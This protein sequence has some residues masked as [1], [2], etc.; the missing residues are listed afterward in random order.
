MIYIN[1]RFLSQAITGVQ[2]YAKE[3]S[4]ELLKKDNSYKLIAPKG[5]LLVPP[6]NSS[7][8]ITVGPQN[9]HIWEQIFLPVF[10]KRNNNPLIINF[11]G[12][13]PIF[14]KNKI[15]TIH[16]LSFWEHPEWF[17]KKYY[18]FYRIFTPFSANKSKVILTVSL[19][20][21]QKIAEL[22]KIASEDIYVIYSA[23]AHSE[24]NKREK[25]KI[26]LTVGSID[27][28]KNLLRLIQ[29]FKCWDNPSY[30]LVIIGGK[31]NSL[32]KQSFTTDEK[33][34][35]TGYLSEQELQDYYDIAE[36]FIY[37]SLYEGFGLPPIEAMHHDIPVISSNQTSL[38]EI[39]SNAVLYIDPYS[40]ESII[41]A[42]EI[43]SGNRTLQQ[44]LVQKGNENIKRFSFKVSALKVD[45]IAKYINS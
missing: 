7:N 1:G 19:Y 43:L 38:P 29:A 8:T 44:E 27:P 14:Y 31:P 20:S 2:R 41:N 39:C 9:P 24:K 13:G 25:E 26:I 17:S 18:W 36:M 30:Q 45:E 23:A 37:P 34:S 12:L 32:A 35:F 40:I 15:I 5:T 33:I 3:L 22:L 6:F 21:K 4:I 10:L 16:D 28:R 11:T 42:F